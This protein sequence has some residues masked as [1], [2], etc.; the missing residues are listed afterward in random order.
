MSHNKPSREASAIVT[1]AGSGIGRAFAL[2]LARRGGRVV[3]ADINPAT[4]EETAQLIVDNG[5]QAFATSCDV[6]RLEQVQALAERAP[7]L[8]G[9]AVDLVIN[10]AGIGIGGRNIGEFAIEDWHATMDVNLWGVIHGCHVFTPQL[11]ELGRGGILNVAST[12]SFA[13]APSMGPYNVTKAAV[14]ALTE[15][16]AAELA[17]SGV[18]VSALCPTF[19]KTNIVRDGR[20]ADGASRLATRLMSWTGVDAGRVA[21]QAL[22]ALDRGQLYMLPQLDARMIWRLKR[23][24]PE[25]Y[26]RGAGVIGRLLERAG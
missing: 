10:N 11:R 17:G 22:D 6:T 26:G 19:V 24:A 1:G 15:T 13:A 12:A 8:L 3:C 16:L 23:L 14:L 20:I 9:A 2:E 7:R 4:A 5:G 25:S 21:R 18:R